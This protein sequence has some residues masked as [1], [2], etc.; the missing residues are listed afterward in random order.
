[1]IIANINI[2]LIT[3]LNLSFFGLLDLRKN[4]LILLIFLE[5]GMVSLSLAFISFSIYSDDILGQVFALLI[6]VIGG[7]EVAIGLSILIV[8]YRKKS[9]ILTKELNLINSKYI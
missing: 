7:S 5:I 9:N 6:L 1:M 8:Y 2:I 4:L 3:L